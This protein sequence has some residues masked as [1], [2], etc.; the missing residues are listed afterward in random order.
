[1]MM[2]GTFQGAMINTLTGEVLPIR[3]S[4]LIPAVVIGG[5]CSN[6]PH[7]H[8]LTLHSLTPANTYDEVFATEQFWRADN[9]LSLS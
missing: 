3:F 2:T 1:M 9:V 8:T 6:R 4:Y 7:W 5:E